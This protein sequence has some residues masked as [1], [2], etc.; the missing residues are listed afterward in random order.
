M[1]SGPIE[2]PS[3]EEPPPLWARLEMTLRNLSSPRWVEIVGE[4]QTD[5]FAGLMADLRQKPSVSGDGKRITSGFAYMGLEPALAWAN[6]CRDRL[7][8]VMRQSIESFG[9][10]WSAMRAT[11][12]SGPFHYVSL[13][14]G[15]GQK[16][17]VVLRGLRRDHPQ[18]C[19]I[20]VDTSTEMLR[21]AVRDL[22]VTHKFPPTNVVALPWD[23]SAPDDIVALRALLTE[24]FGDTAILFSL[25]GNTLANF[26]HDADLLHILAAELIRPQDRL[27]VEVATTP[28]L[29]DQLANEA[30]SEYERSLTFGEFVTSALQRYTDLRIEKD[31]VFYEGSI[32]SDRAL[33]IKMIYRNLKADEIL[34]RL[35]NRDQV[36]FRP[37]DTIRLLLTR[38]YSESGL[39]S[40]LVNSG[41]TL[42]HGIHS[43]C[44]GHNRSLFG[45]DLLSVASSRPAEEPPATTRADD[46]WR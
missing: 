24:L 9:Q 30:A 13:G 44:P 40:L 17:A 26:D 39:K 42:L 10:R 8:P 38:K 32:E 6:A 1:T 2:R 11:L 7:Y 46:V 23:F 21:L 34:I 29:N 22:V 41:L 16:D 37:G 4:D 25:L 3:G 45:M 18:L 35:P 27:L 5:K 20:P 43:E 31:S 28:A 33:L 19:Y 14:P 15:D 36:R 12:S